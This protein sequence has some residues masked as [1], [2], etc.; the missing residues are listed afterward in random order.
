MQIDELGIDKTN[1]AAQSNEQIHQQELRI[2]ILSETLLLQS[3]SSAGRHKLDTR[4][5][6]RGVRSNL[7]ARACTARKRAI[8][9]GPSSSG[10]NRLRPGDLHAALLKRVGMQPRRNNLGADIQFL[11]RQPISRLQRVRL[12]DHLADLGAVN[13]AHR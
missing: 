4:R 13:T 12:G 11:A 5:T 9:S 6:A 10:Q 8:A 3:G 7:H 1:L 2:R